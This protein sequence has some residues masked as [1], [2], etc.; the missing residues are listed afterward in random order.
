ML[1]L[2]VPF[3]LW[4][5]FGSSRSMF[6]WRMFTRYRYPL[7]FGPHLLVFTCLPHFLINSHILARIVEEHVRAVTKKIDDIHCVEK[8]KKG[9]GLEQLQLKVKEIHHACIRLPVDILPSLDCMVLPT[10]GFA[11]CSWGWALMS[12]VM[13][14]SGNGGDI[15]NEMD[16]PLVIAGTWMVLIFLPLGV[17]CLLPPASVSDAFDQLLDSLN[18]LRALEGMKDDV[19][20]RLTESFIKESNRGQ[21]L[22][23]VF[24]GTVIHTRFIKA[25][26]LKIAASAS[27][28]F[29]VFYKVLASYTIARRLLSEVPPG[30]PD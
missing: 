25:L 24:F 16:V 4:W 13:F 10:L 2:G 14:V 29:S 1:W 22:G 3:A 5:E 11:A 20:V 15:K 21:G 28:L 7:A 8:E 27:L 12:V 30:V 26:F 9:E 17:L 23:F 19:Q 18:R 6:S